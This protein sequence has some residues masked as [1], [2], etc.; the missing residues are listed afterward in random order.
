[1]GGKGAIEVGT[2]AA[3]GAEVPEALRAV[4]LKAMAKERT[5]RYASVE[6]F[7]ADLEAYQNGFATRA[8]DAGAMRLLLLFIKR[9]KA[10]SGVVALFLLVAVG[11]TLKLAASERI[12]R[13]NETRALE[14]E[15]QAEA[16][17]KRALAATE[18]SRRETA[19]ALIAV[20]EA[21]EE[22]ADSEGM[23]AALQKIPED[24]RDAT[25]N[26]LERRS[27]AA[28]LKIAPPDGSGWL[29]VDRFPAD[30]DLI[31]AV[32]VN[33]QFSTIHC[34]TGEI[35]PLWKAVRKGFSLYTIGVS[36][37]GNLVG[38]V[39]LK[40]DVFEVEVRRLSDGTVE[41]S[42]TVATL[43]QTGRTD[44][45]AVIRLSGETVYLD[46]FSQEDRWRLEAWEIASGKR[47]WEKPNVAAFNISANGQSIYGIT[48]VGLFEQYGAL[49]G[50]LQFKGT[51][52]LLTPPEMASPWSTFLDPNGESVFHAFFSKRKN[53]RM[54][55]LKTGALQWEAPNECGKAAAIQV[56]K[57]KQALVKVCNRS[58]L[59][60][61][62][63]YRNSET[64]RLI[65]AYPFSGGI[66]PNVHS[67]AGGGR[68]AA[69]KDSFAVALARN[70]FIWR[71]NAAV[72]AANVTH[73]GF[74]R[75]RVGD[76]GK[77]I[78]CSAPKGDRT[79][80]F[81]IDPTQPD[82]KLAKGESTFSYGLTY[83]KSQYVLTDRSGGRVAVGLN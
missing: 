40:G 12:A 52:K 14:G 42:P 83:G 68:I 53:S 81:L 20:A 46:A 2:P 18:V 65:R 54:S 41:G 1:R 64:G 21:A 27:D 44:R 62:F 17:E 4:T 55:D 58:P 25:W 63:E 5:K 78:V 26:Y 15:R 56:D 10:V 3:I 80:L 72:P 49:D 48:N 61:V 9:N 67:N 7:A 22:S 76:A 82:S 23:R 60:A 59:G 71:V 33:G 43:K 75:C 47:L 66:W 50:V 51:A 38:L 39:W 69:S 28:D 45:R 79:E 16:N 31:L 24:L 29:E 70:I 6:E 34:V 77:R 36:Q 30:P 8:E 35:R 37:D 57:E 13:A 74:Y 19:N 73:R 32:Q 11:F